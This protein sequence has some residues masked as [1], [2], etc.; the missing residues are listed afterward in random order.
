MKSYRRIVLNSQ[1][2]RAVV[3]QRSSASKINQDEYDKAF[4][5]DFDNYRES[6]VAVSIYG[7]D[8]LVKVKLKS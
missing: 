4:E 1:Y 5:H 6:Y 3:V 7:L 8:V 2:E